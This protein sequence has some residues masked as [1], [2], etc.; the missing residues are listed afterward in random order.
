MLRSFF[1]PPLPHRFIDVEG[2][3]VPLG[4]DC[5]VGRRY[6]LTVALRG[7][8]VSEELEKGSDA[9]LDGN[10]GE[11]IFHWSKCALMGW[12]GCAELVFDM[13]DGYGEGGK[14]G[15]LAFFMGDGRNK[16]QVSRQIIIMRF[17]AATSYSVAS[18]F[19]GD[20]PPEPVA[21]SPPAALRQRRPSPV[22]WLVGG[23][24]LGRRSG[25]S[26]V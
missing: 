25:S 1:V 21:P 7:S 13:L 8:W 26:R 6:I 20:C 10:D 4:Y 14:E 3:E 2:F 16:E 23:L 11:A 12:P 15:A 5:Y 24:L 9:Y 17:Y 22:R 18:L 19:A